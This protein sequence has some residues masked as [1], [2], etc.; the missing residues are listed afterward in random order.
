MTYPRHEKLDDQI[1]FLKAIDDDEIR[2]FLLPFEGATTAAPLAPVI[3]PY[4]VP[5]DRHL[6]AYEVSGFVMPAAGNPMNTE[7]DLSCQLTVDIQIDNEVHPFNGAINFAQII[8]SS[9][10]PRD[11]MEF[12]FP[13]HIRPKVTTEV[14]FTC[15]GGFVA[16]VRRLGLCLNT[17][18][19]KKPKSGM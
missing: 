1:A 3:A 4:T 17:I 16:A 5:E 19:I 2:P 15:L 6:F 18:Q 14:T 11:G 9:L 8:G 7:A 10:H 12:R 13:Y